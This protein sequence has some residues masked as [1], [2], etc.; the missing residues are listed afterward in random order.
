MSHHCSRDGK[1]DFWSKHGSHFRNGVFHFLV[2]TV[3]GFVF[4]LAKMPEPKGKSLEEIELEL[5]LKEE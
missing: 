5:R 4:I 3:V 2:F 1:F